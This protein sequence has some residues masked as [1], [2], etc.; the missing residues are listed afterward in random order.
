MMRR[1]PFLG[2]RSLTG[3]NSFSRRGIAVLPVFVVQPVAQVLFQEGGAL[4]ITGIVVRNA[5]SYQWQK[6]TNGTTF[7]D[8]S[9]QTT[10]DLSMTN[11]T[12]G[13]VTYRLKATND[14]GSSYSIP[15]QAASV[16]MIIQN[17]ASP[18][19]GSSIGTTKTSNTTYTHTASAG[20]RYF[21]A[22]YRNFSDNSAFTPLGAATARALVT[23]STTNATVAPVSNVN[24]FSQNTCKTT[25]GSA[26]LTA[27]IGNLSSTLACTIS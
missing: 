15:V 8:V 20:T 1:V 5:T 13:T 11:V 4:Q 10:P 16:Y 24:S 26:T 23:W 6:S 17:D 22:F 25:A 14:K 19:D 7:T 9:G 21:S 12:G 2:S 18:T 3:S 27:A